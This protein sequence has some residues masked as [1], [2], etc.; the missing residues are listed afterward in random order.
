ML[1][2]AVVVCLCSAQ[3]TPITTFGVTVLDSSGLKGDIYLLQRDT[4]SLPKFEKL[5]SVG[6]VYT[7]ALHIPPRDFDEGFPG[8]TKRSE[9]FAIDYT[10]NFWIEKPGKYEFA[11]SS[12]DGSKLYIDDKRVIDNDGL[13]G[14]LTQFGAVTL[15]NGVHKIRI[16]YFQG[17]RFHLGLILEVAPP[18]GD[19]RIFNTKHFLP[20]REAQR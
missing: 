18:K 7:N 13:H 8:I 2:I 3:D 17:P 19:W 14:M 5:K 10:G 12:D 9:W 4:D 20:P 11:L 1:A 15:K 16:S 6:T